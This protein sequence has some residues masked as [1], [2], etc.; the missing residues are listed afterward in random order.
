MSI[1]IYLLYANQ[2]DCRRA[3]ASLALALLL[4]SLISL[5]LARVQSDCSATADTL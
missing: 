5:A 4:Y 3:K 2:S 1:H